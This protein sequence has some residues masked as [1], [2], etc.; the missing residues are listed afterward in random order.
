[1]KWLVIQWTF[2]AFKMIMFYMVPI[3]F[4]YGSHMVPIWFPLD[5]DDIP[6][7][8]SLHKNAKCGTLLTL[9]A[10]SRVSPSEG[11]TYGSSKMLHQGNHEDL[12]K[13]RE[14]ISG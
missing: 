14:I 11:A 9:L 13:V 6:Q 4:P 1:M 2:Y 7:N 10:A 8:I 12:R 3:W 5:I